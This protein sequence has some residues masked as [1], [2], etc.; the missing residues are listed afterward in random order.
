M[1]TKEDLDLLVQVIRKENEPI[2]QQLNELTQQ[3]QTT[4]QDIVSMNEKLEKIM[5][6]EEITR[7]SLN[8]VL[9]WID[10]YFRKDYPL[11]AKK[12][13]II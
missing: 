3:M 8:S 2:K 12:E 1:L 13:N 7:G 5:E 11:P 10:V 6:A 4:K 9:E